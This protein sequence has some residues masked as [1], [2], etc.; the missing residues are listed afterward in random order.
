VKQFSY[1]IKDSLG[2]H[3]RPAGL[4]VKLA[5]QFKSKVTIKKGDKEIGLDRLIQ[6]MSLQVKCG[7]EVTIKAD[8]DDENMAVLEI[9]KYMKENL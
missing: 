8:G 1:T 6:L 3:A 7:N 5:G 9:E 2:I 4:L